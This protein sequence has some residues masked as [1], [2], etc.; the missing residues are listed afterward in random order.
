MK[1]TPRLKRALIMLSCA[2]VLLAFGALASG[3]TADALLR[4]Y[5]YDP[6]C[7]WGRIGNGKGLIV[8]CL[9]E[10]EAQ[11]LRSGA[12]PATNSPLPVASAP[13]SS[14]PIAVAPVNSA[15]VPPSPADE[16]ALSD[17]GGPAP[18]PVPS[19]EKLD[20]TV[21]PVTADSG[22]LGIGKLG[23]ARD[24]Y[25]KCVTDNGGLKDESGEVH[26]RFMLRQR[27]RAEGVSVAK[28]TGVS[29]E[30]ARCVSDVVDRRYVGV[31]A[32][33][34]VGATVVIKFVKAVK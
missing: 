14:G 34:M 18:V 4:R 19:N 7:P 1:P 22:T 15:P 10:A 23:A 29:V 16:A 32:E 13:A 21:G 26:V 27:G 11:G 20:I 9:T 12:L 31:P 25:L 28:R 30:A 6:A 3:E 8:R 5:P 33:P 2:S 17:A 24:K